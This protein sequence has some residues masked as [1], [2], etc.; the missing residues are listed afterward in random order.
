MNKLIEK[1][2]LNG[3]KKLIKTLSL[4]FFTC[5]DWLTIETLTNKPIYRIIGNLIIYLYNN[6]R[7]NRQFIRGH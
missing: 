6:V 2:D 3:R 7:K 5:L 4:G 1:T